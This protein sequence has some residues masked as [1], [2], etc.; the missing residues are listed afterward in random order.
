MAKGRKPQL[1]DTEVALIKAMLETGKYKRQDILTYF[2]RTDR[3]VNLG[4]ISEI[5]IG[6][7]RKGI[8]PAPRGELDEF[9]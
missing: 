4:R 6:K 8:A 1:S 2:S 9:L 5:A 3:P 7:K